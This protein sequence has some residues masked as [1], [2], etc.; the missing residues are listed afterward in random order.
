MHSRTSY[1]GT[2][3]F[4]CI[5]SKLAQFRI[6]ENAIIAVIRISCDNSRNQKFGNR[7]NSF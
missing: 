3:T 4:I 2:N 6:L 1:Y 5:K 7:L